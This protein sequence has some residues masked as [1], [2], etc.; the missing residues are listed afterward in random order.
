MFRFIQSAPFRPLRSFI[1]Y[2]YCGTIFP[3]IL[4]LDSPSSLL[5]YSMGDGIVSRCCL[6]PGTGCWFIIKFENQCQW[7]PVDSYLLTLACTYSLCSSRRIWNRLCSVH[8]ILGG[9]MNYCLLLPSYPCP[10]PCLC[11]DTT[12]EPFGFPPDESIQ[13]VSDCL[14]KSEWI[15]IGRGSNEK[16]GTTVGGTWP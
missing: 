10:P 8:I 13:Y 14:S 1:F 7:Q 15:G 11:K 9:G 16:G 2:S 4:A 5:L 12:G 6:V 3:H